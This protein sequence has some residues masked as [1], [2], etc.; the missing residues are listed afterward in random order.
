MFCWQMGRLLA[1]RCTIDTMILIREAM[2]RRF[3]ID[4][5]VTIV[6]RKAG[7]LSHAW[8]VTVR[9]GEIQDDWFV[10]KHRCPAGPKLQSELQL[11]ASL[12]RDY[13][14]LIPPVIPTTDG[15]LFFAVADA[16]YSAHDYIDA[17]PS[18]D[19]LS[20]DCS[21]ARI[22]TGAAAL[23]RF[24]N[25]VQQ[26]SKKAPELA[27][28]VESSFLP[29]LNNRFLDAQNRAL[30]ELPADDRLRIFLQSVHERLA[31]RLHDALARVE[32][33]EQRPI[34]VHGDYHPGNVL[35]HG[36]AVL[37][38]VDLEFAHLESPS[39]DVAYGAY[40]FC[41]SGKF[42]T[43]NGDAVA[44]RL[45][46]IA[47]FAEVYD[48]Q[49]LKCGNAGIGTELQAFIALP[50]FLSAYWLLEEYLAKPTLRDSLTATAEMV[51]KDALMAIECPPRRL[52]S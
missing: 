5:I 18:V 52:Y 6:P 22:R 27:Q 17:D 8:R 38:I 45:N 24:H 48:E 35:W 9:R 41:Q 39:Y 3:P 31:E 32:Q 25:A 2:L 37:S 34:I 26:L 20:S 36:N 47:L 23:A 12:S 7:P 49:A 46:R 28:K 50:P 11:T 1:A 16:V 43:G 14:E 30:A 51:L 44:G 15:N 40:M 29:K 21:D 33:C 13:T 4:E 10:K 42:V 19:W